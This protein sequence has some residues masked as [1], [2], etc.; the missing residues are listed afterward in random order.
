MWGHDPRSMMLRALLLDWLGQLFIL[1]GIFL[2]LG[3]IPIFN[4]SLA[5]LRY[6]VF[7]SYFLYLLGWL[8]GS[9]TVVRWRNLPVNVLFERLFITG[10]VTFS[11][12]VSAR[13]FFSV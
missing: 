12:M 10:I 13:S 1:G 8:F 6:F 9:Y 2:G 3:L 5:S 4:V 7:G 11:V